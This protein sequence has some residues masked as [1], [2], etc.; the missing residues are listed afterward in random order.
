MKNRSAFGTTAFGINIRRE[1]KRVSEQWEQRGQ[2]AD[3]ERPSINN[4][5]GCGYHLH[6]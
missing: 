6:R 2:T 5:E 3:N 1:C 4:R